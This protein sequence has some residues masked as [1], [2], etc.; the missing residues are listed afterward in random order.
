MGIS[1]LQKFTKQSSR[2]ELVNKFF[3]CTFFREL[4]KK[5]LACRTFLWVTDVLN[6]YHVYY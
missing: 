2:K 1:Y 4:D 5:K 3:R 6:L